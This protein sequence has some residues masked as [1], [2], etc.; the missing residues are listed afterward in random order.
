[1]KI[2][3]DESVSYGVVSYLRSIG[4]EVIAIAE[5]P[6]SGLTDPEVFAVVKE[7]KANAI[8]NLSS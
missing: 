5:D 2:L 8:I 4:Y 7:E 1:M 3:I 6:T